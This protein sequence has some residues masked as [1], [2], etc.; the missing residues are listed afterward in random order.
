MKKGI[1][2]KLIAINAMI[3]GI[4]A[5][6]TLMIAPI[7]YSQIQ[8]RLSEIIVFLAFYNIKYIPG[9]AL[10]C[11]IANMFSPLGVLDVIFGTISTILVCIAMYKVKSKYFAAFIGAIITGIII[12]SELYY[13][14]QIPFVINAIYVALGELIVLLI[15]AIIFKIL[16]RNEQ[17]IKLFIDQ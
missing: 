5:V 13:A 1:S 2:V 15:G 12:G 8:F 6:L 10:G 4:Y 14:Y 17:F 16:E 11:V 3:A 9:L 7:A